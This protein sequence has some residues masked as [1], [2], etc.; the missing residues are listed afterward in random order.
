MRRARVS[1]AGEQRGK[2]VVEGEEVDVEEVISDGS[3]DSAVRDG[4]RL[5]GR[6]WTWRGGEDAEGEV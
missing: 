1:G 4:Y 6:L 2:G 3:A 5:L